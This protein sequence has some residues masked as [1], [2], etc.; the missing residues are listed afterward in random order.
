MTRSDP[1][2]GITDVDPHVSHRPSRSR[3]F[4]LSQ[5]TQKPIMV[6][7]VDEDYAIRREYIT[8]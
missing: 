8:H 5:S 2:M 4:V 1:I 7:L 3:I 6:L